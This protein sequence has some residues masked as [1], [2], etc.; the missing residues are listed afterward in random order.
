M[1]LHRYNKFEYPHEGGRSFCDLAIMVNRGRV[2]AVV[3]QPI[4]SDGKYSNSMGV[5]ASR[6]FILRQMSRLNINT[7]FF[8][9]RIPP[10]IKCKEERVYRMD[11]NAK[12]KRV[13]A[14]EMIERHFD[15]IVPDWKHVDG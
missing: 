7:N 2:V 13:G 5:V 4:N 6:A 3:T 9:I 1:I 12:L 8:Y 14:I 11:N 15:I 10:H